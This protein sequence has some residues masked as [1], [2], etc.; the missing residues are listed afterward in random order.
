[1]AL[2]GGE[3]DRTGFRLV[4]VVVWTYLDCFVTLML[5]ISELFGLGLERPHF[6]RKGSD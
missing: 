1:M 5:Q 2:W 6:F 4:Q 3:I